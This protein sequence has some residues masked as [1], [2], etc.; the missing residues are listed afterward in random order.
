MSGQTV[1]PSFADN[2][3]WNVL[4]YFGLN[5]STWTYY[6]DYDTTFCNQIYSKVALPFNAIGYIRSDSSKTYF[7]T[8]SNCN[9]K[10]YLIYDYSLNIGDTTYVGFNLELG[11][12]NQ[13]DT[14]AFILSQI[15]TV[16]YFGIDRQRFKMN[17]DRCNTGVM[18]DYMYWIKGIGSEQHPFY[19]LRCLCDF[20]ENIF[21]LLCFDS[22]TTQLYQNNFYNT[23]DTTF[24]VGLVESTQVFDISVSPNPF[25]EVTKIKVNSFNTMKLK[26]FNT[27][28]QMVKM[29]SGESELLLGDDLKSGIYFVEIQ[30]DNLT[31]VS[32]LVKL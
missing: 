22:T 2:P 3:T 9:E 21:I 20:C 16:N 12:Q 5:C 18:M 14:N 24:S 8:S 15:D 31:R 4:E 11:N 27:T 7:R 10:E 17:F 29:L 6:Y 32:K 19:S 13:T 30:S 25:N 23:C 26:V 1:F 28:G